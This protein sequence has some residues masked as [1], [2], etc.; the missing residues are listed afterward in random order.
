[1][2]TGATDRLWGLEDIAALIEKGRAIELSL[3]DFSTLLPHNGLFRWGAVLKY[4]GR[5]YYTEPLLRLWIKLVPLSSF[6]TIFE[7]AG[8]LVDRARN[9]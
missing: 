8:S 1:M 2:E 3:V 6:L 4:F 5:A 9:R 7:W